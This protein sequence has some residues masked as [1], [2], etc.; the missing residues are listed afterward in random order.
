MPIEISE[1]ITAT[2][3]HDPQAYAEECKFEAERSLEA[4]YGDSFDAVAFEA[5]LTNLGIK[6]EDIYMSV[7][8]NQLYVAF[9]QNQ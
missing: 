3:P 2:T 9:V 8:L 7:R 1:P 5:Y 4:T 6:Y